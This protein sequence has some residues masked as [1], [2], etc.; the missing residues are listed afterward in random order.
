VSLQIRHPRAGF[1]QR[2]TGPHPH[3][4]H[5]VNPRGSRTGFTCAGRLT[6][7]EVDALDEQAF[8]AA[9]QLHTG[10]TAQ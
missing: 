1:E 3:G 9:S 7:A 5:Y 6:D 2:C 8:G 4:P 10:F